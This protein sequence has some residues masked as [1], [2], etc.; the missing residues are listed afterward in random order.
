MKKAIFCFLA[1]NSSAWP[2][3]MATEVNIA[4]MNNIPEIY[5]WDPTRLP[6]SIYTPPLMI[7]LNNWPIYQKTLLKK[8]S[9]RPWF[10]IFGLKAPKSKIFTT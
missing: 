1:P 7:Y 6:I 8:P 5:L 4:D 9:E 10:F 2:C 3:F